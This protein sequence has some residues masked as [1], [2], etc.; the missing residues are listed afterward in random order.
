V[1]WSHGTLGYFPTYTLGN[2]YAAQIFD[3]FKRASPGYEKKFRQG[4]F[5]DYLNWLRKNIHSQGRRYQPLELIEKVTG[6]TL[7]SSYLVNHLK[8]KI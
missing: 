7:D 6:Q 8:S 3:A 2:L 5:S 1:H 4:N